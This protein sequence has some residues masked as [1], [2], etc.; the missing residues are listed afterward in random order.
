MQDDS[1]F[2]LFD[3][4]CSS[5]SQIAIVNDFV[6]VLNLG[7]TV[8][9]SLTWSNESEVPFLHFNSDGYITEQG[10]WFNVDD[11]FIGLRLQNGNQYTY[12]W[13]RVFMYNNRI[14]WLADYGVSTENNKSVIVGEGLPESATS[15][16]VKDI[17]DYFDGRD[18]MVS[19]TKPVDESLFS[20]YRI[21]ISKANDTTAYDLDKMN[22]VSPER[23]FQIPVDT[24]DTKHIVT[25]VMP[26]GIMDKDGDLLNPLV[27][28]KA[29]LLNI[30]KSGTPADNMLSVASQTFILQALPEGAR[31]VVGYDKDNSGGA[32]DIS[33]SFSSDLKNA[34]L[35]EYRVFIL[36]SADES[37][38]DVNTALSLTSNYYTVQ[39]PDTGSIIVS[40]NPDQLDING[41]NISEDIE[42]QAVV[43][44]V[45]DSVFAIRNTLSLFS[46]EFVLT[47]PDYLVAGLTE[48]EHLV[49]HEF[50]P[51]IEFG[52]WGSD[53]S[54]FELDL[55]G[56]DV[57]DFIFE[58]TYIENTYQ[59]VNELNIL[60]QNNNAVLLCD[61]EE[62]SNLVGKLL[63]NQQ[64][65]DWYRWSNEPCVMRN[66]R[67]NSDQGVVKKEGH[68][69]GAE[70]GCYIGLHLKGTDSSKYAWVK[71]SMNGHSITFISY[72][73]MDETS[74]IIEYSGVE[75]VAVPNPAKDYIT[76]KMTNN[77][78]IENTKF[79]RIFNSQGVLK[80]SFE[81]SG[82]NHKL[83]LA[84]YKS[85]VY[86]CEIKPDN[87]NAIIIKFIV[88]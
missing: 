22:Q 61:H 28:Y 80:E 27:E 48:G 35:K 20:A 42:Y 19:F 85:G 13:L 46:R 4:L 26:S 62:D 12:A 67:W 21:I 17:D 51:P 34:F 68:F 58:G 24:A 73:L 38:F 65:G 30:N 10:N 2:Y 47:N 78:N 3:V 43:L 84:G 14:M 72:G 56:D 36:Q 77:D 9:Q 29:H 23:Y 6:S 74:N 41:N 66:Y 49:Y 33:V 15:L 88:Y 57:T 64:I 7:D 53:G 83:R 18:V 82:A 81:F 39:L 31:L 11:G 32:G 37:T 44:S 70:S 75:G 52:D 16:Y 5:S 25:L 54:T 59:A 45:V 50:N 76:L 71:I 87:K 60:P 63:K 55:D 40:V 86:F 79:V 8:G 1:H 69:F